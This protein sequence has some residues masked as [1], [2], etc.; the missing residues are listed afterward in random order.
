MEGPL[1]VAV[2]LV[3]DHAVALVG[4]GTVE[5]VVGKGG[6]PDLQPVGWRDWAVSSVQVQLVPLDGNAEPEVD[7][8]A[9]PVVLV[10]ELTLPEAEERGNEV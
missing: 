3:V 5:N 7:V 10:E 4:K 2:A 1:G 9:T 8:D 6:Q